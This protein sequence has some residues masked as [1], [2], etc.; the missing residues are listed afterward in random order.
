MAQGRGAKGALD[1]VGAAYA[2]LRA[3]DLDGFL[4]LCHDDVVLTQ[5][6]ALPWGGVHRG[7][8][9]VAEFAITLAGTIDSAVTELALFQAGDTVVQYGRTAGTVRASGARFDVPET[10]LWNV[11]G[12]LVREMRFFIDSEAMIE[13]LG[14]QPA[15]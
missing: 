14:E 10:H 12:G 9:G 1:V 15:G 4:A 8:D 13:A 6:P 7:R 3:K 11:S 5:D 2:A